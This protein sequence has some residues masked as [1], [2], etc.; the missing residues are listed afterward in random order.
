MRIELNNGLLRVQLDALGAELKSVLRNGVQYL[1]QG[2]AAVWKDTAPLLFP[3]VGRQCCFSYLLDGVRYE[4]PMHGFAKDSTF[5]VT[6]QST[7]EAALTLSAD[8][9]TR[10]WYPFDFVLE[11]EFRLEGECLLV[12]RRVTNH[13]DRPM[14]FSIGEHPGYC[15]SSADSGAYLR[16]SCTEE[17]KRWVLDDEIIDH[18]EPF[19]Y[20]DTLPITPTLFDRG[21]LIFKNLRSKRVTLFRADGHTVCVEFDDWKHLGIWAKPNAPYICI[22]PWNGLASSK[23]SSEDI[24]E[25]ESIRKLLPGAHEQFTMTVRFR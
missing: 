12:T 13:G 9:R 25:K 23:G 8:A 18:A 19:L 6:R 14:P 16:F 24:W 20:S 2:D 15:I 21:A 11:S 4:M 7:A 3:V 1:W 17:E 10:A 5:T 22:E